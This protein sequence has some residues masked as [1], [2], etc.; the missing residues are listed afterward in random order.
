MQTTDRA[1]VAKALGVAPEKVQ[2]FT[3]MSGGDYGRRSTPTSDYVVEAARVSAAYRQPATCR[4]RRSG[5]A[6]TTC[7]AAITARWCCIGSTSASTAAARCGLAARRRRPV[8]AEGFAARAHDDSQKRHR[9]RPHRRRGEQPVRFPDAGLGPSAGRRRAGPVMAL[10]RQYAY[11]VRDGDARRRTRAR[12]PPGSGRVP[13]GAAVQPRAHAPSPGARTGRRQVGLRRTHAARRPCVGVAMHETAGT[14]VAYVTEVSIEA[15][16]PRVHRVTAGV[17]AG[18]IVNPTGAE[19]QIQA[20]RCSASR[21]PSRVSRSTSSMVRPATASPTLA[22]ADAGSS[23]GGRVLRPVGRTSDRVERGRR[24][25]DRTGGR[26]R[27]VRSDRRAD[28]RVAVRA[29]AGRVDRAALPAA[30]AAEDDPYADRRPAVAGCRK[31]KTAALKP[32]VSQSRRRAS[33]RGAQVSPSQAES[34]HPVHRRSQE[35]NDDLMPVIG[36]A[37]RSRDGRMR[38]CGRGRFSTG[39]PDQCRDP[40][41]TRT[42]SVVGVRSVF[43]RPR[44]RAGVTWRWPIDAAWKACA[45]RPRCGAPNP[46]PPPAPDST[47]PSPPPPPTAEPKRSTPAPSMDKRHAPVSRTK[48]PNNATPITCRA[49]FNNPTPHRLRAAHRRERRVRDGRYRQRDA[50]ACQHRY[51]EQPVGL[52]SDRRPHRQITDR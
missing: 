12:G 8:G 16:Q 14:V 33:Q 35:A 9:S 28:A 41:R 25:A 26:Q 20:V 52:R 45:G 27:R 38:A 48:K 11:G 32:K 37:S 29:D 10:G 42:E 2:I 21:R 39:H 31:A 30:A 18:R 44:K 17:H 5:R 40:D 34:R 19:A 22:G 49:V 3:M 15:R 1:A 47:K 13:D 7:A 6:R 24:A 4:S 51:R 36:L 50:A 43:P 46:A 23:A